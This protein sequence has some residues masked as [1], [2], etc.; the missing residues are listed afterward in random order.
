MYKYIVPPYRPTD[1]E[2]TWGEW[3]RRRILD[4]PVQDPGR[5]IDVAP[6]PAG[7]DADGVAEFVDNGRPEYQR[8]RDQKIKPDVVIFATGYTQEM[9]FLASP[10]NA[11][12]KAYPLPRD[13]DV[14]DV[15]RRD[16]PTVGF[17]GFV[18]PGFG[19]IP[20]LAEMQA[21]LF[22]ANLCNRVPS[23]LSPEDEWHYRILAPPD[24]R[25]PYGVEHDSYVYQ[26]AKDMDAAPSF[27][28]VL[29]LGFSSRKPGAWWR[30]P[31]LWAGAPNFV[32]KMRLRGPWCW[33]GAVD[34]MLDCLWE[35]IS[36]RKG[37]YGAFSFFFFFLSLP[38]PSLKYC[39]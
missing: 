39:T 10:R 37:M 11:G 14:R 8:I 35:V 25:I 12:R 38:Y 2:C 31:A 36:R 27:S 21:M 6:F 5:Y 7:F 29:R 22:V 3:I 28:E 26:L 19:A 16:D 13:A 4:T 33:D 32:V 34:V 17:I 30:L 23:P 24:A 15:W 20:P 1:A 18:R 9:P